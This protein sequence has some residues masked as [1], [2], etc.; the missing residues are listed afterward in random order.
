MRI[1]IER[2]LN[3]A[4]RQLDKLPKIGYKLFPYD[5]KRV[6]YSNNFLNRNVRS[7]REVCSDLFIFDPSYDTEMYCLVLL[8]EPNSV[9]IKDKLALHTISVN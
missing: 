5:G 8:L 1:F 9:E 2:H 7:E 6:F 4:Q 3:N